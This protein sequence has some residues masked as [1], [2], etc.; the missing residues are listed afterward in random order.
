[1]IQMNLQQSRDRVTDIE[2]KHGYQEEMWGRINWE[3][4]I[5]ICTFLYKIDVFTLIYKI[6][7]YCIA[8]GALLNAL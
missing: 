5:D 7:T 3:I 4:G 8:Q 1:M 6:R 2:D